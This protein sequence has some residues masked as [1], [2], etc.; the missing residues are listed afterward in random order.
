MFRAG[1]A[2]SGGAGGGGGGKGGDVHVHNYYGKECGSCSRK[3]KGGIQVKSNQNQKSNAGKA[4]IKINC[5]EMSKDMQ[6]DAIDVA[7]QAVDKHS[8]TDDIAEYIVKK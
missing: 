7:T 1:D 6:K 8:S 5:V 2:G 4:I 3:A